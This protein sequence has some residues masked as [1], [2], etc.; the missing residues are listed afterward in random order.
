MVIGAAFSGVLQ[1]GGCS[2]CAEA[3]GSVVA[4]R[5]RKVSDISNE[6]AADV[7]EEAEEFWLDRQHRLRDL[8]G[9]RHRLRV[10]GR[11]P[12]TPA[13]SAC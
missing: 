3:S 7:E 6:T 9:V 2:V 5:P 13:P 4:E 10:R 12:I 1:L 8:L 11:M